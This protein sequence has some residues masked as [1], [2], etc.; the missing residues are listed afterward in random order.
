M[1]PVS[2]LA[3]G[4]TVA[5]GNAEGISKDSTQCHSEQA[6]REVTLWGESEDYNP[7]LRQETFQCR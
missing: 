1:S 6:T 7:T 2:P 3:L 4:E 5:S